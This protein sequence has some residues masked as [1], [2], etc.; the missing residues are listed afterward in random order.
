MEVRD[1][2]LR[3]GRVGSGAIARI[4]RHRSIIQPRTIQLRGPVGG[5]SHNIILLRRRRV[6][7]RRV[8][9]LRDTPRT[10]GRGIA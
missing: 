9:I 3:R 1:L 2:T 4:V 5:R 8:G 7:T 10:F 6:G